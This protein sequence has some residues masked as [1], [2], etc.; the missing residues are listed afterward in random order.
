MLFGFG[1]VLSFFFVHWKRQSTCPFFSKNTARRGAGSGTLRVQY[2]VFTT[3][4][5]SVERRRA[6][7]EF[8]T[9]WKWTWILSLPHH[10][11]LFS[12][13]PA[14]PYFEGLRMIA[15]QMKPLQLNKSWQR[16]LQLKRRDWVNHVHVLHWKFKWNEK[17]SLKQFN[18]VAS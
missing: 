1:L 7:L 10:H 11:Q 5:C 9:C 18:L 14:P 8:W 6:W 13:L 4:I 2:L 15:A 16:S 3:S 17:I 12:D